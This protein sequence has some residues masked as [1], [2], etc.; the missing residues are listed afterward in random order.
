MEVKTKE[1][2]TREAKAKK[3]VAQMDV[4][5]NPQAVAPETNGELIPSSN[6][7]EKHISNL[8]KCLSA[9]HVRENPSLVTAILRVLPWV[10]QG[11]PTLVDAVLDHFEQRARLEAPRRWRGRI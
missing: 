4:E 2:K 1:V 9:G 3:A 11:D 8:L 7:S 5:L 10:I 6:V